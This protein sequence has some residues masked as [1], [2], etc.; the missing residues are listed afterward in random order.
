MVPMRGGAGNG[1]AWVL[2]AARCQCERGYLL[3]SKIIFGFYN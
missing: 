2:L 3:P 1:R